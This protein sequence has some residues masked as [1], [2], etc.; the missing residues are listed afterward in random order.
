VN[1][2]PGLQSRDGVVVNLVLEARLSPCST[3]PFAASRAW[4]SHR[5]ANW[6]MV[7]FELKTIPLAATNQS[8]PLRGPAPKGRSGSGIGLAAQS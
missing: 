5:L 6:W 8:L 2:S 1:Y 7:Q 3:D 4:F